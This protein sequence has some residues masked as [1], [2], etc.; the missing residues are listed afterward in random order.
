MPKLAPKTTIIIPFTRENKYPEATTSTIY[1]ILIG[2]ETRKNKQNITVI[3]I[4]VSCFSNHIKMVLMYTLHNKSI[5]NITKRVHMRAR[6][7]HN[8]KKQNV[9]LCLVIFPF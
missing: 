1:P 4:L 5:L 9:D 6:S 2:R 7:L 3:T 8:D